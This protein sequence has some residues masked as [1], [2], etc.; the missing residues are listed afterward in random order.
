MV[1]F[2]FEEIVKRLEISPKELRRIADRL[3][4]ELSK[5]KTTS[6]KE[7][8]YQNYKQKFLNQKTKK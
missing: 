2:N 8:I 5:T 6:E 4:R 3:E 1:V 7:I